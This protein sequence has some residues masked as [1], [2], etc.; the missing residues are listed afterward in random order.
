MEKS[1]IKIGA[2]ISPRG[3]F[4]EAKVFPT[5]DFIEDRFVIGAK[6]FLFDL[7]KDYIK[8]TIKNVVEFKGILHIQF[9]EINTL[10]E[11]EKYVKNEIVIPSNAATLPKGYVFDTQ[12][13]GL[14]VGLL[15]GSIIGKVSEVITYT[16][17]KQIIVKRE[18]K[19][20]VAIPLIPVFIKETDL[21][22]K[23]IVITPIEGML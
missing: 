21:D 22:K 7:K 5:T 4:G 9:E 17:Q 11:I 3:L 6:V 10:N 1:Y 19:S 15:D 16:A 2:I 12:L 14:D 8:V 13:V 23:L 20:N 18:G